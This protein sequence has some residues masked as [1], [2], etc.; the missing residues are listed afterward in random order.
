MTYTRKS[1]TTKGRARPPQVDHAAPRKPVKDKDLIPVKVYERRCLNMG[2]RV[3]FKTENRGQ[4]MCNY[5]T[6]QG[7]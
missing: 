2:C 7:V 3:Q 6:L 5:H 1:K 4:F